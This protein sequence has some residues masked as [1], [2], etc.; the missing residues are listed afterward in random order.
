MHA[1]TAI[2]HVKMFPHCCRLPAVR[3]TQ[4]LIAAAAIRQAKITLV[5]IG[6]GSGID[7]AWLD[8]ISDY[9]YSV[10]GGFTALQ[11]MVESIVQAAC[12]DVDV[13]VSCSSSSVGV[14]GNS[15][16]QLT[17]DNRGA[18]NVT[19]AIPFNVT[20]PAAGLTLV[21]VTANAGAPPGEE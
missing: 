19:A 16:V 1:C 9:T 21:S 8:K 7:T 2:A 15:T 4:T 11:T 6:V 13:S 12:T 3:L 20:L 10:T 18:Y 5:S 17:F 14:G